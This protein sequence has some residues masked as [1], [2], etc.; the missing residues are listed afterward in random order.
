MRYMRYKECVT[1]SPVAVL[2]AVEALSLANHTAFL[3]ATTLGE[4][5]HQTTAIH[6]VA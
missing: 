1:V 3:T 4:L 2:A 6:L 5:N